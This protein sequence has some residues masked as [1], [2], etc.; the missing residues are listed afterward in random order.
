MPD[1]R[2]YTDYRV[3]KKAAGALANAC[4]ATLLQT[5]KSKPRIVLGTTVKDFPT[6]LAAWSWLHQI[7]LDQITPKGN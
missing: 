4:G 3:A 6:W 7:R 5:N 1:P 2:L